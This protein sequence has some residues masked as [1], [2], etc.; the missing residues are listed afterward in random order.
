M[1]QNIGTAKISIIIP[2]L[3]EAENIKQAIACTQPS[4]NIEV[5]V[6]DG[7]HKMTLIGLL[8]I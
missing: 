2:V 3:N 6:V 5:I 4:T 1:S 7:S 8:L